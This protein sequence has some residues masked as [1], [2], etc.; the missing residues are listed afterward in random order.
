[1]S[2]AVSKGGDWVRVRI[3]PALGLVIAGLGLSQHVSAQ[4]QIAEKPP[5]QEAAAADSGQVRLLALPKSRVWKDDFDHMK[6]RRLVRVLV[7]PSRTLF[8][9]DKGVIRG[10]SAEAAFEFENW[11]NHRYPGKPYKFY[12][13]LVPTPR[14]KL[15][16]RLRE[17]KGDIIAANFTITPE[18]GKVV[19]FARPWF[20]GVKE[21]LVTGPKA[22]PVATLDDLAGQEIKVRKSSSYYESLVALN[23]RLAKPI[24][25]A[26][27]DENLEDED[28]M[29]MASAGLLPWAVVDTHKAKLWAAILPN[30]TVREDITFREGG[31]IAWAIRKNSPLLAKELE[32]F[33]AEASAKPAMSDINH[34]Y[35]RS[36]KPVKNALSE[37][38]HRKFKEL[39]AYFRAYGSRFKID[40]FLLTAQGYQESGLDQSMK[41]KSGAVGIMQIKPST[42]REKEINIPDIVTRAEDNFHAGAKY[43]RFLANKY[44]NDPAVNEPNRVLMALAAYNAGPG[45]LKKF[46]DRA[47]QNGLDPNKWFGNVET[48]AAAVVGQETVQYVGNIY[49]Y[50]VVYSTIVGK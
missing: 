2:H 12:V 36:G 47:R 35:Y 33:I 13:V 7:S 17:G 15:I 1:M 5:A 39:I 26:T 45:N 10:V 50:Y 16:E 28:L 42:A 21:A 48:G 43:L 38:S 49:K 46:R 40:P 3:L 30:V 23:K 31:D 14:D 27:I 8:F 24:K 41:M 11:L 29:E 25:V 19:D 20:T 4:S 9:Q 37:E 34:R 32:E 22:P 44:V 6:N 18:R